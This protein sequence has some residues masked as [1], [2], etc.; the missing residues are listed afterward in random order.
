MRRQ[1][2][3]FRP[4]PSLSNSTRVLQTGQTR[5]SRTYFGSS[6]DSPSAIRALA[7]V[8][9]HCIKRPHEGATLCR[10]AIQYRA[11]LET[12]CLNHVTQTFVQVNWP[13]PKLTL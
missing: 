5:I 12:S 4:V 11:L 1:E 9:C 8:I 10:E 2:T 3:H 6:I 13:R 7:R